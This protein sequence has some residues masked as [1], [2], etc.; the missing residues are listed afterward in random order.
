MNTLNNY[1]AMEKMF[2]CSWN[3]KKKTH[4]HTH[5]RFHNF[6]YFFNLNFSIKIVHLK[7]IIALI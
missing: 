2:L 1:P 5:T 4:T 3:S 7:E 6:I